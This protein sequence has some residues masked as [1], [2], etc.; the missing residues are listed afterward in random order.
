MT[1]A[2][3]PKLVVTWSGGSATFYPDAHP[4]S[5]SVDGLVGTYNRY[6]YWANILTKAGNA[7]Y[8]AVFA[9]TCT[10]F[11]SADISGGSQYWAQLYRGIFLFDTSSLD[12]GITI[13]GASLSL[14]GYAKEDNLETNID[15]NIYTSS[16]VSDTGLVAA[17]F[18]SLGSTPLCD[19][20][21]TYANW[22]LTGYND[23]VF[24]NDGITVISK[25]GITYLGTRSATHDAG[26]VEPNFMDESRSMLQ[27]YSADY[28]SPTKPQVMIF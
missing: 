27:C 12:D 11:K 2:Y 10:S 15:V 13:T 14:Y 4:E 26:G 23:F 21:I 7:A 22:S 25:T 17:D 3:A 28:V 20:P 5:T 18:G 8:D 6:E 19:T 9:V 16:P 24:N 1:S